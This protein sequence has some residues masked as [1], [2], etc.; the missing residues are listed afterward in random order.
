MQITQFEIKFSLNLLLPSVDL[1]FNF[2]KMPDNQKIEHSSS[3]SSSSFAGLDD[4]NSEGISLNTFKI[5]PPGTE[6]TTS[7]LVQ[8]DSFSSY[9]WPEET[10]RQNGANR[11]SGQMTLFE[12]ISKTILRKKLVF[13][14]CIQ[15]AKYHQYFTTSKTLNSYIHRIDSRFERE[16]QKS[17]TNN[18]SERSYCP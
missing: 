18:C 3:N 2:R 11:Q 12:L 1:K 7:T 10:S 4:Q 8:N 14:K 16:H 5:K 9:S 15:I 6:A 17:R 13:I